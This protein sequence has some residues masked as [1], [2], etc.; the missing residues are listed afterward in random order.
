MRAQEAVRQGFV[1]AQKA[2]QQVLRLN[3][4]RPELAGFIARKKDDAPRFFRITFKHK[5]L[6]PL[7]LLRTEVSAC[8]PTQEATCAQSIIATNRPTRL[9]PGSAG[10]TSARY[11]RNPYHLSL[12]PFA[13]RY[14]LFCRPA[15]SALIGTTVNLRHPSQKASPVQPLPSA[16]A[17]NATPDGNVAQRQ[18]CGWQ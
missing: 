3:I 13:T 1:F 11:Q 9:W 4:G 7:A 8:V 2:Q 17:A 10:R 18:N 15:I 5:A 16:R 12:R 6:P 14:K